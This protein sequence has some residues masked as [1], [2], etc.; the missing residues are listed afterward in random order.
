[1]LESVYQ[2]KPSKIARNIFILAVISSIL[3]VAMCDLNVFL[4]AACF[5]YLLISIIPLYQQVVS[6]AS[7]QLQVLSLR[8]W[9]IIKEGH[10]PIAVT[11]ASDTLVTSY[12]LLLRFHYH[13]KACSYLILRDS[14]QRH[15][16][17]SLLLR[18]KLAV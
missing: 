16:F 10:E 2:V 13:N 8:E 15:R 11:L 18:L 12:I 7:V 14:M 1:M 9:L 3:L 5:I 17:K 6:D 4:K